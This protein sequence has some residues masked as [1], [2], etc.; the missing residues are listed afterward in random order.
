[1]DNVVALMLAN[2]VNRAILDRLPDLGLP[3]AC[4]VA[5][6]LAQSVWNGIDRRA[7][8][9]GIKDYDIFYFD[10]ADIGWEAEDAAIR[11]VRAALA[12]LAVEID[13]K[14]Q[15]RVHL[16]YEDRFGVPI[17]PLRNAL[18]GVAMF[19][20]RGT[21]L[22]L[23]HGADGPV[24]HAPYGTAALE[25]G[26]LADNPNCPDRSAFRGKAESY[27]ARWPWLRIVEDSIV[28][29]A[30]GQPSSSSVSQ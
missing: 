19:P 21:C 7:P 6:A 3:E 25:A 12:D 20:V 28:E 4:L 11:R 8:Q 26:L 1:M 10:A 5:G 17:A 22:A 14:N 16:W 13:V 23:Q 29:D 18:D 24:L 2:P 27:R 15:A 30:G 9:A